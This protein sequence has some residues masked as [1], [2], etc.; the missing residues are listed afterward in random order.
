M[1]GQEQESWGCTIKHKRVSEER[2]AVKVCAADRHS[3]VEGGRGADLGDLGSRCALKSG[4]LGGLQ[5]R[6]SEVCQRMMLP[7]T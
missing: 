6:K 5:V 4:L 3:P 7:R 2:R 1:R